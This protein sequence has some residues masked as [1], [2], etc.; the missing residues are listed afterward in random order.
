LWNIQ[1]P[2]NPE[3]VGSYT[4]PNAT[5]HNLYVIGD[6]AYVSYYTAGIRIFD[7]SDPT[8]IML[9]DEYDTSPDSGEG[10]DGAFGIDP[11]SENGNI[12]IS[13]QT[14]LYIFS[15]TTPTSTDPAYPPPLP[16]EFSLSQNYPNPFNPSTT[17]EFALP[18]DAFVRLIIT[19]LM[20]RTAETLAEDRF[21]AGRHS[22]RWTPSNLASGV[23][24][25]T[26][27]AGSERRTRKLM[28]LR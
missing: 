3:R 14:G 6:Y 17:L 4:D 12:Y 19:D 16:S 8:N 7:V 21:A 22:V 20:G 11:F 13:D 2:S 10:F 23:Y 28:Y 26:L 1:D 18:E 5:V 25:A 15:F 27:T 24:V 9:A